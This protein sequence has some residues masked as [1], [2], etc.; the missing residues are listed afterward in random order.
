MLPATRQVM[1]LPLEERRALL[2]QPGRCFLPIPHY[3]EL[4]AA[5]RMALTEEW[6]SRRRAVKAERRLGR[7]SEEARATAIAKWNAY[8][9]A[10]LH[11][12]I[13]TLSGS[14]VRLRCLLELHKDKFVELGGI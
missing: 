2:E 13:E 3:L 8:V 14:E 5:Q 11:V 7:M 10:P 9:Q 6:E 1:D 12:T 4:S